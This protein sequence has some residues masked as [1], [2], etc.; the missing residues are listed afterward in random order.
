M[1]YRT[2][3]RPTIVRDLV[4][5]PLEV[6]PVSDRGQGKPRERTLNAENQAGAARRASSNP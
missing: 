6:R 3:C 1:I 5:V 2:A 4:R